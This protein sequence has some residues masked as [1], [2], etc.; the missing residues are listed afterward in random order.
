MTLCR[1]GRAQEAAP[2]LDPIR[3]NLDVIEYHGYHQILLAYKGIIDP[4]ELLARTPATGKTAVDHATIG[5]GIGN[6]HFFHGRRER[7][8]E[9]FEEIAQAEQWPAF[10]RIASEV[11]LARVSGRTA[12]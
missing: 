7:A 8:R 5:Y 12:H 6:W 11:E 9:I 2:L 10:G 4:D 3:E 1:A